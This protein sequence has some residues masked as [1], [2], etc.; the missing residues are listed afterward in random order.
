MKD[1][2]LLALIVCLVLTAAPARAATKAQAA[3]DA[4]FGPDKLYTIHLHVTARDWEL[5]QPNRRARPSPLIADL[6]P[7]AVNS[8]KAAP[9][10][11]A[12]SPPAKHVA[13]DGEAL[14]PNNFGFE[15]VYVKA[16]FECDGQTISDVALRFK[17]NSS[18]EGMQR[19]LKRPYKLDFDRFVHGRTF[20]GL[21]TLN[22]SNNA[23]DPWQLREALSFA[24]YRRAGVPSPRTAFANVYLTVDGVHDRE[25]AGFY[26]I[27]EELDDKSF[28]RSNFGDAG[29]LL[30]KPEGIRGLPYMGE[31]WRAYPQRYHTK[32]ATVDPKLS[33]QFID[34]VK[35]VNYADDATFNAKISGYLAVDGFLRY[36]AATVL[37]T[38]L[39]SPLVTNHNFYL[40]ENPSDRKVWI[41]PWDMNLSFASYGA[42]L[43]DLYTLN[44][45]RPWA[46]ENKLLGRLMAI[47]EI[48]QAYRA[49]LRAFI[50]DFFNE[51]GM[52]AI[53][54]PMERAMAKA[55]AQA[56]RQAW[57]NGVRIAGSRFGRG[58]GYTLAEYTIKRGQSVLAQLD[59][60]ETKTFSP[61]PN[62]IGIG[63]RWGIKASSDFG[64]FPLMAQA[65]RKHADDDDSDYMLSGREARDAV[66]A[67][68]YN[69]VN[70]DHPDELTERDLA[71]ALTP[72]VREFV[73]SASR[74]IFGIMW[75]GS[76]TAAG[77]WASAVFRDADTDH[78]G[79]LTLGELTDL[80]Q[81]LIC[82]AD[83]DLD[84]VLDEREIIEALD[85][86]AAPENVPSPAPAPAP[87]R[88]R[89][90][91]K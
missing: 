28:L 6:I 63:N 60:N 75:N 55:D 13:V 58:G 26:T 82:L 62:P 33:K 52:R 66:A 24:V 38:N 4:F 81:R 21:Q 15:Y 1:S 3:A 91:V 64:N 59:G 40:Y 11:L 65:L 39:D 25:Y 17:G 67:F 86:L 70:E 36:L 68:F 90:R 45:R 43:S 46:G 53:A 18:F 10:P 56:P 41:M 22:L 9:Q 7:A 29:G 34:F 49:H 8:A 32:T 14:P 71:A 78:D 69:A 47:P 50:A 80:V 48:D 44:I 76:S 83:R 51:V 88:N 19:D 20:R 31:S 35:L 74:G 87:V 84:G 2:G 54:E 23:Y 16:Q 61:R 27:V 89:V 37:L 79:K 30:M 5:M 12:S 72:L 77:M 85:M 73:P 42:G 57:N